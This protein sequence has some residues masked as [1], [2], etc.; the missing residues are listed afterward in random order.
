MIVFV[1]LFGSKGNSRPLTWV[2]P[3]IMNEKARRLGLFHG[4]LFS[5]DARADRQIY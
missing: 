3:R 2:V 5:G 1:Q 4:G